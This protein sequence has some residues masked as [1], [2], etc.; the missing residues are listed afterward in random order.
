MPIRHL[1][2]RRVAEIDLVLARTPLALAELH[3]N[4][5]GARPAVDERSHVRVYL[6]TVVV[7][8]A[9]NGVA[10]I[11]VRRE[12]LPRAEALLRE[13]V[14][15]LEIKSGYGLDL[16]TELKMLAVARQLGEATPVCVRTTLLA[17]QTVPP[18][19]SD[20][21]D[22]Y[23]TLICDELLP[24]VDDSRHARYWQEA[25]N[26]VVMRMA[27]IALIMGKLE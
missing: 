3:G 6:A 4:T 14:T 2:S 21:P 13:G 5:G 1:E 25:Y 9:E 11:L 22:D 24:E 16:E 8:V 23:V 20:S 17:A 15:T 7:M 27:L 12:L 10:A 18:E 26:G 19:F